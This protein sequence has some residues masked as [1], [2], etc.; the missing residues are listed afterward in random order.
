MSDRRNGSD[1][2]CALV[3]QHGDDAPGGH[4]SSWLEARGAEQD[5]YRIDLDGRARRDP[6]P[7][8]Y[9]LIVML[10][11]EA[12]AFD[13]TVA[14]IGRE[15]RLLRAAARADVP[16]L[17][18]CFGGQLLARALGGQA[19][20]AERSEIGWVAL[21]T[22]DP[23]LVAAG[24]W[25]V[26]HHD[27]FTVPPG[28]TL[29]ADSPAAPQAYTIGRSLGV[30]F[31]PEATPEIVEDWVTGGRDELDRHGVDPDRLLAETREREGDNRARAWRLFDAFAERV[32]GIG[33][34]G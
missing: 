14:W 6:D 21:R 25:L 32:A 7:L 9:D 2:L 29:L 22:R 30:Q 28:A 4:V 34:S 3:I 20:R 18:I 33:G 10:G 8:A 26:W 5:V 17:G 31:H 1:P 19:M 15:Q 16:M 13:D 12:A 27:T 24:P 11:S 23:A